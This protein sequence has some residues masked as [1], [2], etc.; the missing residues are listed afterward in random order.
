MVYDIYI[1]HF[2]KQTKAAI[3]SLNIL[4]RLVIVIETIV[5]NMVFIVTDV[6]TAD[7]DAV[8]LLC[9]RNRM[10]AQYLDRFHNLKGYIERE[11]LACSTHGR[12]EEC[13]KNSRLK[14]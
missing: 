5:K 1:V 3:I 6:Y 8:C 7:W 4:I 11:G 14:I 9:G 10:S 13:I 2:S 12:N